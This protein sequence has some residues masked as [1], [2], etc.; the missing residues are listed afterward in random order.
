MEL[1]LIRHAIAE[2]GADDD[3]RPL[4]SRG[5]RRFNDVVRGLSRLEIRFD[6]ILHSPKVRAVQTADLLIP[7][8]EGKAESTPLLAVPPSRELLA[9]LTGNRVAVVGHEPWLSTLLAWL[10]TGHE[11]LGTAFELKKGAVARLEG[12]PAPGEMRLR[13]VIPPAVWRA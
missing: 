6:R 12:T 11:A 8:L 4:S 9:R 13:A 2:D 5:R 3:A 10:V 7:L 1:F